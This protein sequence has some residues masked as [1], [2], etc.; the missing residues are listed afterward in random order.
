MRS[1]GARVAR[2]E[3]FSGPCCHQ[4]RR[5]SGSPGCP[6]K[7]G[8]S[9]LL[10]GTSG[11]RPDRR[12]DLL[13]RDER[14]RGLSDHDA[15]GAHSSRRRDA[16]SA[17]DFEASIRKPG[18]KPE[19]IKL[20]LITHAHIDHAGTVA[21]FQKLANAEVRR[22]GSRCSGARIPEARPIFATAHS[23]LHFPPVKAER[24]DDRWRPVSLGKLS[25]TARLGAGHTQRRHDL[26]HDG[27]G[28][29]PMYNVVFPCC[30]G[31][32]PGYRLTVDPSYPGIADD[33]RR[34][35]AMLESLKPDIWL[36]AHTG[37]HS[38]S[39]RSARRD[40]GRRRGLG[41]SGW[42]SAVGRE[43]ERGLR[44]GGRRG[45]EPRPSERDTGSVTS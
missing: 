18:F 10:D 14:A 22:D 31:I 1:F 20:L 33:Y 25:M 40:L 8:P 5:P 12:P 34:T 37:V 45:A 39:R 4:P 38:T 41:R 36:T 27:R 23:G 19:D 2:C 35:F 11:A 16:G 30:T 32:N 28:R 15:Q 24:A 44:G 7:L 21:H 43:R 26:D 9:E 17:K 6:C 42:L 29:R 13:R 3:S